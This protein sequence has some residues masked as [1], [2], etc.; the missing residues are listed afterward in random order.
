MFFE[1]QNKIRLLALVI[2]AI[3]VVFIVSFFDGI[4]SSIKSYLLIAAI[5]LGAGF[6]GL[7][8]MPESVKNPLLFIPL[9]I[10]TTITMAMLLVFAL[11]IG[12]YA[13]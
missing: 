12:N 2:S 4:D 6:L 3:I 13:P 10:A 7:Q 1:A 11:A 8:L 9:H 5:A